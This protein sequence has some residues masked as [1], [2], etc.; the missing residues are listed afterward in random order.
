MW[1]RS[2][3]PFC[4]VS[5]GPVALTIRSAPPRSVFR[6][7]TA[8]TLR[9]A[10]ASSRQR[11]NRFKSQP[12][13]I[14]SIRS[15]SKSVRDILLRPLHLRRRQP[16]NSG[17]TRARASSYGSR[18]RRLR[19]RHLGLRCTRSTTCTISHR[20]CRRSERLHDVAR[21]LGPQR[22]PKGDMWA[23]D[24]LWRPCLR[25]ACNIRLSL[26]ES[27]GSKKKFPSSGR[28]NWAET[29]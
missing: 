21:N 1:S 16:P 27:D 9:Q 8:D 12:Y 4:A 28:P 5:R 29:S 17:R 24:L 2:S 15:Q 11:P 19:F 26:L 7:A 6:V 13:T 18:R 3:R 10:E 20:W 23:V 25:R 14:S 22:Q